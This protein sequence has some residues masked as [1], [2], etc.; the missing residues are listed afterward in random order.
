MARFIV[1]YDACVLYPSTLRS[2]LMYL[3]LSGLFQARWTERIHQ[4]WMNNL[5][6]NRP[7]L[8]W[9]KLARTRD[10]MNNAVRG[11]LVT[12]YQNLESSLA[13][14]DSDDRHVLAAAIAARAEVIV[15]ENL[16]DFP[17]TALSPYKI[18]AQRPDDFIESLL[19][20]NKHAVVIATYKHWH[21]LANPPFTLNEYLDSLAKAGLVQA[22]ASLQS[23]MQD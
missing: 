16:A 5:L 4:E 1:I 3:A 2:L 22:A 6:R 15:T 20:L 18:E 19:S 10:E 14:P 9:E 12:G 23:L 17:L 7:D 13:L 8:T 21:S 11:A